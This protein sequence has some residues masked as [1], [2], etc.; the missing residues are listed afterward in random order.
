[1][2][3]GE[4]NRIESTKSDIC[5]E[6]V[7]EIIELWRVPKDFRRY[8]NHRNYL[9]VVVLFRSPATYDSL[10][11]VFPFPITV[12]VHHHFQNEIAASINRFRSLDQ[13][14]P[15]LQCQIELHPE[16]LEGATLAVDAI[17]CSNLFVG[18]R[19]IKRDDTAYLFVVYFQPL[20]T[21]V[22][23]SPLFVIKSLQGI[24]NHGIQDQIDHTLH[25]AQRRIP[26]LFLASYGYPSYNARHNGFIDISATLFGRSGLNGVI[27]HMK[28]FMAVIPL[29]DLLHLAKNFPARLLKHELKFAYEMVYITISQV[30]VREILRLEAPLTDLTQ[31]G[32][33]QDG[34]PL[35]CMHIEN[36]L[37]L[38]SRVVL[39]DLR[40]VEDFDYFKHTHRPLI[41]PMR[42]GNGKAMKQGAILHIIF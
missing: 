22:K 10:L 3:E 21:Y 29:S 27:A 31:T 40:L 8:S 38:V 28:C 23:Y 19:H 24:R 4:M 42:D 20:S 30:R 18:M 2:R 32:K 33:M 37:A 41:N 11:N 35:A 12:S 39:F 7:R 9:V 34:Y 15:F 25:V 36:I 5:T 14:D 1:M 16:I 13:T 17:S 6:V 26:H